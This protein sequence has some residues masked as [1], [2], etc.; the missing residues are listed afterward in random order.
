MDITIN[1]YEYLPDADADADADADVDDDDLS[2]TTKT[3]TCTLSSSSLLEQTNKLFIASCLD[4]AAAVVIGND[5]DVIN[6]I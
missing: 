3:T 5:G 4:N 6:L 2:T 1:I